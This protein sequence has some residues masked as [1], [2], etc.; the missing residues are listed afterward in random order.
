MCGVG[1]KA[2]HRRDNRSEAIVHVRREAYRALQ[3]RLTE[4]S[5]ALKLHPVQYDDILFRRL[6]RESL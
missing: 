6:N 1:Y 4:E 3:V 2:S 5:L